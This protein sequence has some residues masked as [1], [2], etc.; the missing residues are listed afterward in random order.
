M[1]VQ[2]IGV[3]LV[4][5]WVTVTTGILF[6]VMKKTM[7]LRVSREEEIGGLDLHEHGVPGYGPDTSASVG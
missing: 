3:V 1:V 7:G 4:F 6:A 5:V 2:L